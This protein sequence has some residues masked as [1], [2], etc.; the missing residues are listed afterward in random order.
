MEEVNQYRLFEVS[1]VWPGTT[2]LD[3]DNYLLFA[4]SKE[5]LKQIPEFI[6]LVGCFRLMSRDTW[7]LETILDKKLGTAWDGEKF[8]GRRCI[9]H[10]V[11][12][13]HLEESA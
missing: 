8:I 5:A 3:G 13:Q 4:P 10:E 9:W 1:T 11:S 2:Q 7:S 12:I 6:N